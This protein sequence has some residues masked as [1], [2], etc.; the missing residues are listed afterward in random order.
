[1]D[2]DMVVNATPLGMEGFPA[3]LPIDPQ[4]F[5]PG[6][7]AVDIIYNP[8]RT[9][10]LAEAEARGAKTLSGMQM[11]IYQAMDAFEAWTGHRPSYEAMSAG[12]GKG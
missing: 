7:W 4:V 9:P 11:L 10:F 3:E 6:Q 2:F 8:I 12:A 5:R 1:M